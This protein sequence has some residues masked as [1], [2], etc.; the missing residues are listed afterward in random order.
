MAE[1]ASK[2]VAGAGL[3]LGIAGTALGLGFL[4]NGNG[5]GLFGN[6]N[7]NTG[8]SDNTMVTRYELGQAEKIAEKQAKIDQLEAEQ[9][10]DHKLLELYKYVDSINLKT[11]ETIAQIAAAQAVTNQKVVDEIAAEKFARCCADTNIVNYSNQTFY[12]KLIADIK[13]ENSSTPQNVYNPLP[14]CA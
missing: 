12:A 8:C 14:N 7:C 1:F 11:G 6:N 9:S 13:S 5:C 10:T 4:N 3:G 2:G